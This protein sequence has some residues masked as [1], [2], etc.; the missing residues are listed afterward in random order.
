VADPPMSL[1]Q[2][3]P[4]HL[5]LLLLLLHLAAAPQV[6]SVVGVHF[7]VRVRAMFEPLVGQ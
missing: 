5:L 3:L 2:G 4:L 1:E 6:V 7:S